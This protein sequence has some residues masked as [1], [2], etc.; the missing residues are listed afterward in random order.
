MDASANDRFLDIPETA[1]L[2]RPLTVSIGPDGIWDD[3]NCECTF[4]DF[5]ADLGT[6]NCDLFCPK[7]SNTMMRSFSMRKRYVLNSQDVVKIFLRHAAGVDD[8]PGAS[9]IVSRQYGV[10]PKAVRDIWNR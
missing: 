8:W 4:I 3:F 7:K 1:L 2:C 5:E 9:V 10:S 6:S